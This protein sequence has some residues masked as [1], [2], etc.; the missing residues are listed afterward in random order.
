MPTLIMLSTLRE[1]ADRDAYERW[2]REVD[3]P[4][5]LALPS[6]DDWRLYRVAGALGDGAEAPCDY[7]EIAKVND[8]EQLERD[9]GTETAAEL[10]RALH[11]HCEPPTFLTSEQVA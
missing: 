1:G 9:L 11:E 10:T 4:T 5:V 3:R 6:I 2:A 7:V 8:L